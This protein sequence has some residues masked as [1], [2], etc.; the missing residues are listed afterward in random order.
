MFT[1]RIP[2]F[3]GPQSYLASWH[4]KHVRLHRTEARME[5]S[6]LKKRAGLTCSF[7]TFEKQWLMLLCFRWTPRCWNLRSGTWWCAWQLFDTDA[8][9]SAVYPGVLQRAKFRVLSYCLRNLALHTL[10]HSS[11]WHS[12]CNVKWTKRFMYTLDLF[13]YDSKVCALQRR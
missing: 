13:T 12:N 7:Q 2:K 9:C 8:S 6:C 4:V 1:W 10:E 3:V 11:I 5:N